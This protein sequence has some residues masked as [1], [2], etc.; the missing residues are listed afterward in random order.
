ML[1]RLPFP[2]QSR[3]TMILLSCFAL[4]VAASATTP[5][6]TISSPTNA[7]QDSS[8]V[9]YLASA[10]SPQCSKGIAAMRIYLA[11]S[12]SA[13]SVDA[14]HLDVNLK[15][16][17]GTY[18]TV[19]QARDNCGGVGKA[20]VSIAVSATGLR[21]ARF[22]YIT[23]SSGDNKPIWEYLVNPKT[24]SLT[25]TKQR[26]VKGTGHVLFALA[27]DKGGNR[28]YVMPDNEFPNDDIGVAYFIDRRNG[29]LSAVPGSPFALGFSIQTVAVHPSGKF[30][31]AGTI[32]L[33][34]GSP[35]ILV[36]GVNSD[37]SLT[38]LTANPVLT[39]GTPSAIA[40]DP[41]GKYLY[42]GSLPGNAIEAFD[43]NG[44]SGALT[45]LPGSPFTLNIPGCTGGSPLAVTDLLGRYLYVVTDNISS[46]FGLA[47][48]R[49][50]GTLK[51]IAGSPFPVG[52]GNMCGTL[53]LSSLAVEPTGRFLYVRKNDGGKIS[54][55]AINAGNGAL[56]HIKTTK[57]LAATL[58]VDP[59]GSYLYTFASSNV[60]GHNPLDEVTGFAINHSTGDLTPLPG[61]PVMIPTSFAEGF[62]I[63]VTP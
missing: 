49:T 43:I 63:V 8:T 53:G 14:N 30:I 57:F 55:F 6:V 13:Y 18:D 29:S 36:F 28:L 34:V 21:P 35:G 32:D 26:S 17:A 3:F 24:G 10:V 51:E 38:L 23:T 37:G 54:I 44:T 33:G 19:V 15:L 12:V 60:S 61:L 48:G 27:A 16:A 25:L 62:N 42:V 2:E 59:S 5:V 22:L 56:R 50:T 11:P 20:R 31:F 1:R 45:P 46:V 58:A 40:V 39:Q 47:I 9:H 7:S 52:A 41:A 4:G